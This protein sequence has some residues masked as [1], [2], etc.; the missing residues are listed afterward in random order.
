MSPKVVIY[1]RADDARVIEATE[2][3]EIG[4]WVRTIVRE[5][6]ARWHE[7]RASALGAQ[8]MPEPWLRRKEELEEG[9]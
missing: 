7:T 2:G 4:P 5:E 9:A 6:I 3:R 8:R 1:V